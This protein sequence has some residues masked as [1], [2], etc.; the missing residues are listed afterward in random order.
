MERHMLGYMIFT[1]VLVALE[2][3]DDNVDINRAWHI[4]REYQ[5]FRPG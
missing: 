4:I 3:L 2:N 1:G 5:E